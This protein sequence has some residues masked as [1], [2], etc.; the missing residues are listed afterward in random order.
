MPV[1][2]PADIVH[3]PPDLLKIIEGIGKFRENFVRIVFQPQMG[4][5]DKPCGGSPP[6]P[7]LYGFRIIA[8]PG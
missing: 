8:E 3:L 1:R 5:I 2:F 4:Q 6:D 7:L